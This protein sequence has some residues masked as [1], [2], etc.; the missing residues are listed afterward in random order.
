MDNKCQ[1]EGC[2][3]PQAHGLF[4]YNQDGS[5][6]WLRVCILHTRTIGDENEKRCYCPRHPKSLLYMGACID[7]EKEND[8][9]LESA[10]TKG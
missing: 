6:E 7:C 10:P 2:N 4:R 5:K 8:A 3:K 9:R 1:V